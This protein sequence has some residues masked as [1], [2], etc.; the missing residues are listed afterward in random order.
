MT[1]D[2]TPPLVN[3][4][5]SVGVGGLGAEN[6]V[7]LETKELFANLTVV[8]SGLYRELVVLTELRFS[9]CSGGRAD[10]V[11]D[12]LGLDPSQGC[13]ELLKFVNSTTPEPERFPI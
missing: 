7:E 11:E 8:V 1:L 13:V 2:D 9:V 12:V 3:R 4:L 6:P 10:G 5:G